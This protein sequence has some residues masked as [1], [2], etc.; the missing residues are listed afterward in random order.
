MDTQIKE[1]P[2]I[3]S[4]VVVLP[5]EI[6]KIQI[7]NQDDVQVILQSYQKGKEIGVLFHPKNNETSNVGIEGSIHSI[8]QMEETDGVV[9]EIIARRP[10]KL[11]RRSSFSKHAPC[12][13]IQEEVFSNRFK[14]FRTLKKIVCITQERSIPVEVLLNNSVYS[15]QN[16]YPLSEEE[17]LKLL[18][19]PSLKQKE[20]YLIS[21]L[22]LV[23]HLLQLE[24]NLGSRFS[25]N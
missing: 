11:M 13:V 6:K 1:L 17:K 24:K 20:D 2:L 22:N 15:V 14:L 18:Q 21:R 16:Y 23:M 5:G 25:L 3:A 9:I 19:L 10:I 4:D 12:E 7:Q 8:E